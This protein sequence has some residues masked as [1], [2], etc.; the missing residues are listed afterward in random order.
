MGAIPVLRKT[1]PK[2]GCEVAA[3]G[4]VSRDRNL[5][6]RIPVLRKT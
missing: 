3:F 4:G 2:G 1:Q 5:R 6:E